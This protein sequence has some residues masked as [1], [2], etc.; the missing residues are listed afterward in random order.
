VAGG[1]PPLLPDALS[2]ALLLGGASRRMGSDKAWLAW[3]GEPA[4]TRAARLLAGHC[5]EVL[6]VGG[7]APPGTPGRRIPDPPG[8]R[9]ALRGLVGAL[10]AAHHAHVLVLAVDLPLVTPALLRAL[11]PHAGD[12]AV[13]PRG[14]RGPEPL[15]A[16]YRRE[17]ALAPARAALATGR[18]SLRT[19]LARLRV[20]WLGPETL[21]ALDPS[22]R[23]LWNVNTPEARAQARAWLLPAAGPGGGTSACAG[24][25]QTPD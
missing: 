6:L 19:L 15:C 7:A 1:A 14:A 8:P 12:E 9:C 17:A 16:L 23:A 25:V 3:D 2:G 18:L 20:R 5:R 13:V 21:A 11:A 22:G 24:A 4:A 10:A